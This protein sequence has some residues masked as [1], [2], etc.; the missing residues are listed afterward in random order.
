MFLD[1]CLEPEV[2]RIVLLDAP[3][4]LGWEQWRE[5]GARY[6]LGL[7]AGLLTAGM[8]SGEIR[9]Q[10]VDPLAHALLG[11]STRSRCWSRGPTTRRRARRG[12]RDARRAC[13]EAFAPVAP[14]SGR[15]RARP[16]PGRPPF[17]SARRDAAEQRLAH[18]SVAA[19]ADDQ[20]VELARALDQLLRCVVG[21][22][23]PGLRPR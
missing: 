7:I 14:P 10:P 23:G 22:A 4:V 5:I 13:V 6:G 20:Q 18:R 2:Q 1:H 16:A 12:R 17:A 21:S 3:A 9:R 15:A 8:E 19:R 11:R